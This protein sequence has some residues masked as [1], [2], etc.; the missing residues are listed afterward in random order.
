ME[1]YELTPEECQILLLEP[2]SI[3]NQESKDFELV[4]KEGDFPHGE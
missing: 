1:I 2:D 4:Q 3:L